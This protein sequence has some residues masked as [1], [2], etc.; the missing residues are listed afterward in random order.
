MSEHGTG[1]AALSIVTRNPD[2]GAVLRRWYVCAGCADRLA[3]GLGE[4]H[5]EALVAADTVDLITER[6]AHLTGVVI[7]TRE[8]T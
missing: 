4:P 2:G 6:S 5:T 3:A 8:P 1:T 7:T